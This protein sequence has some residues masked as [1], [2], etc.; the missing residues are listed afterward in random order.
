MC[1]DETTAIAI[2]LHNFCN[3]TIVDKYGNYLWY[4]STK[5]K[6]YVHNP[7]TGKEDEAPWLNISW[8]AYINRTT[9]GNRNESI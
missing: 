6:F 5:K 4:C 2:Y 8:R 1:I 9:G 7:N 3:D